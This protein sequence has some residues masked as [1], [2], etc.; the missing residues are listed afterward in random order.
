VSTKVARERAALLRLQRRELEGEL[1]PVSE[2]AEA[3]RSVV[4]N[5]RTAALGLPSEIAPRMLRLQSIGAAQEIL[6]SEV[7]GW[8]EEL[9]SARI[10]ITRKPPAPGWED[11]VE[12]REL[13]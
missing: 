9:K 1:A 12:Y 6:S 2:L 13:K 10:R 5:L 3:L 11:F 8:L 7:R 4:L